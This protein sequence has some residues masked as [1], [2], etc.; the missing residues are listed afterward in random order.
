MDSFP[1]VESFPQSHSFFRKSTML[2]ADIRSDALLAAYAYAVAEENACGGR[3]S[4]R[5]LWVMWCP[6]SSALLSQQ[7]LDCSRMDIM[8]ALATAG[9]FGNIVK[10]NGS[11]SG[12]AVGCQGEVG[13][14]CAMRRGSHPIAGRKSEAD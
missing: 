12:A 1:A 9:L 4:P 7:Q 6:S 8:R 3:V 2:A 11:I 13:V 5:L 10:T 14:A